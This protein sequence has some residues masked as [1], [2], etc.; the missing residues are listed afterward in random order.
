MPLP[1]GLSLNR[2]T[3]VVSGTPTAAG[4][5]TYTLRVRDAQGSVRDVPVSH[6]IEP[7]TP[8][9]ISGSP[10]QFATR[11][12][13]YTY[14]PSVSGGQSPF[15]WSIA[16][17]ILPAGL[18]LNPSTGVISGTPTSTTFL[19]Q[20]IVIRVVDLVGSAAQQS[21]TLNYADQLGGAY[22]YPAG[23]IGVPYSA[24]PAG[25]GGHAPV[26]FALTSGTL[27]GGLSLAPSTG[28]ISG[29]PTSVGMS[30]ITVTATDAAGQTSAIT[31]GLQIYSDYIP[32]SL[33]GGMSGTSF[34][35][36][37]AAGAETVTPTS[38]LSASGGT[39]PR[40]FSW[41]R[42]SGSSKIAA[43]APTALATGFTSTASPGENVSA[44]FRLMATDG[45]TSATYDVTIS[46]NN[47]YVAPSLSGS[48]PTH[49]M[50]GRSYSGAF[51]LTGGAAPFSYVITSGALPAGMSLNAGSGTIS[52]TPTATSGFGDSSITVRVTD[53]QGQTA[54]RSFT[55]QYRDA[56]TLA[57][58]TASAYTTVP[59]S[60]TPS[61]SGGFTPYSFAIVSGS[62]PAG[63]SMNPGNGAV[64]GTPSASGGAS[65]TMRMTDAQGYYVDAASTIN[66]SAY[67]PMNISGAL[68]GV[69]TR[70]VSYSSGMSVSGGAAPRVWSVRSGDLPAGLSINSSTGVISGT[71]TD[72]DYT[73]RSIVVRVTDAT[74]SVADS[75][76]QTIVYRNLPVMVG[77]ALTP[78]IRTQAIS[79]SV[80]TS[81]TAHTPVTYSVV[82]GSL[83][84]G[85]SL[86]SGTGLI[87]GTL[88]GTTYT[89]F[90]VTIRA[91]DALGN[92]QD[93]GFSLLY[94]NVVSVSV[95]GIPA[96]GQVGRSFS[97]SA[98]ASGG[99]GTLT[100][101]IVSGALPSGLSLNSGNGAVTGTPGATYNSSFTVRATDS[102]GNYADAARS[103]QVYAALAVA[104]QWGGGTIYN[105]A[106]VSVT[107]AA[108]TGGKTPYSYAVASG[109]LPA[110][111]SLNSSTGAITG[112]PTTNGSFSFVIRITDAMSYTVDTSSISGAVASVVDL[113][114]ANASATDFSG[115]VTASLE[116]GSGGYVTATENGVPSTVHRWLFGGSASAYEVRFTQVGGVPI[117][118]GGP[119]NS[120]VN[121]G[122]SRFLGYSQGV[123]GSKWGDFTVE[124]RPAGGGATLASASWSIIAELG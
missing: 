32:V 8:P 15:T 69:A 57:S 107:G 10:P 43:A 7:Y 64:T 27:P 85:A 84:T 88:T 26:T 16:T 62:L 103:L 100:Y 73:D 22:S 44:T 76:S 110:G 72:T 5:Y 96:E 55:L 87:S 58:I 94:G 123:P 105:G 71:P 29:T 83:P 119:V 14:A 59:F 102:Y 47:I 25:I 116:I 124:I 112:T 117:S 17:G 89:T 79:E 120:W 108:G 98:S 70:S 82:S 2:A 90:N 23:T 114:P 91:T 77:R 4:T 42:T 113:L 34:T 106:S 49:A 21:Y 31:Q 68:T 122:T 81:A 38:T 45:T 109:S 118:S 104:S 35:Y 63:L 121:L 61:T 60:W 20:N 75:S 93:A 40:T 9:A 66:V 11:L 41:S 97:G 33:S 101:S 13:P 18:S 53:G 24:T 46:T 19:I 78:R 1:P 28:T 48:P 30:S 111:L 50:R 65:F 37:R 99:L 67:T 6:V 56:L 12:S 74:M 80:A 36:Q 3:G 92:T 86:N 39:P 115:P 51:T 52:G 95:S 54:S